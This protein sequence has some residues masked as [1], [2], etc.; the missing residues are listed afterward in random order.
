M[1]DTGIC[2]DQSEH[3][4]QQAPASGA[5]PIDLDDWRYRLAGGQA[6]VKAMA[7]AA[8][9]GQLA[10][11]PDETVWRTLH[12]AADQIADCLDEFDSDLYAL[13]WAGQQVTATT[14]ACLPAVA[15]GPLPLSIGPRRATGGVF[16]AAKSRRNRP[17]PG[18]VLLERNAIQE[19]NPWI[20]LKSAST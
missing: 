4:S 12:A 1:H 10:E 9:A 13:A 20:S 6:I 17:P 11:M 15:P 18:P 14:G 5:K 7:I 8:E 16:S 2:T 3:L 19:F